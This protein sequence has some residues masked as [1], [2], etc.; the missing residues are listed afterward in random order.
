MRALPCAMLGSQGA[1]PTPCGTR[2][3][4]GINVSV[5]IGM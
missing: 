1:R 5:G 2:G 3:I 4:R